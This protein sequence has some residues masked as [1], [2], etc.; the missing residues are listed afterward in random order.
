MLLTIVVCF[1]LL[2]IPFCC[3]VFLLLL[4]R[5]RKSEYRLVAL[6]ITINSKQKGNFSNMGDGVKELKDLQLDVLRKHSGF[7]KQIRFLSLDRKYSRVLHSHPTA[8]AVWLLQVY[9]RLYF[10]LCCDENFIN[11]PSTNKDKEIISSFQSWQAVAKV[12]GSWHTKMIQEMEAKTLKKAMQQQKEEEQPSP[13]NTKDGVTGSKAALT[14]SGEGGGGVSHGGGGGGASGGSE[15]RKRKKR[16]KKTNADAT[17]SNQKIDVGTIVNNVREAYNTKLIYKGRVKGVSSLNVATV[18]WFK[19]QKIGES[20][21]DAVID[22]TTTIALHLL[23]LH[24]PTNNAVEVSPLQY[25]PFTIDHLAL[26]QERETVEGRQQ[27]K[28]KSELFVEKKL[29]CL[30]KVGATS[31]AAKPVAVQTGQQTLYDMFGKAAR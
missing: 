2:Y 4:H 28:E 18:D 25:D 10:K 3:V 13:L 16:V 8:D 23:K 17:N 15:K 31:N 24:P 27:K 11:R 1:L 26:R 6:S 19:D 29:K 7:K 14:M 20:D 21:D 30:K 12:L 5:V 9:K 22:N